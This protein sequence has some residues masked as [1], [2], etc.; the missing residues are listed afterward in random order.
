MI[1]SLVIG[2]FNS[3]LKESLIKKVEKE[4]FDA[5][6]AL[7]DYGGDKKIGRLIFKNW[8]KI[9]KKLLVRRWLGNY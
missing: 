4:K 7:G 8:E 5:V 9:G 6:L 1:R 3:V 2:D